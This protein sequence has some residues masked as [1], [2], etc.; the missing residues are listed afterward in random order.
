MVQRRILRNCAWG[1]TA[2]TCPGYLICVGF[3]QHKNGPEARAVAYGPAC[4][5][6]PGTHVFSAAEGMDGH[7]LGLSNKSGHEGAAYAT[8]EQRVVQGSSPV[9]PISGLTRVFDA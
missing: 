1:G 6:M 3:V 2:A 4:P 5:F 8:T 9:A 7:V